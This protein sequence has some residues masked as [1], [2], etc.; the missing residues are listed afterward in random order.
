MCSVISTYH[1][2]LLVDNSHLTSLICLTQ[3][4]AELQNLA[5]LMSSGL[6][7][8]AQALKVNFP[9]VLTSEFFFL[10]GFYRLPQVF[11]QGA[12]YHL[13]TQVYEELLLPTFYVERI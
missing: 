5:P 13:A 10:F 6:S 7:T 8:C 12:N 9:R 4:S 11:L 1:S 3:D 2:Q